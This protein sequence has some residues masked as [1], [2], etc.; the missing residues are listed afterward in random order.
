MAV[1]LIDE[2]G[3]VNSPRVGVS[4]FEVDEVSEFVNAMKRGSSI[5]EGDNLTLQT[6]GVFEQ[7]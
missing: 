4:C 6:I 1:P 3:K 5:G 7:S 2:C